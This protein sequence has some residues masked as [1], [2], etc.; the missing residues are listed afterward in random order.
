MFK[1]WET[2]IISLE[3]IYAHSKARASTLALVG[4]VQ[5][6]AK[7]RVVAVQTRVVQTYTKCQSKA[8]DVVTTAKAKGVEI[9]DKAKQAA[10]EMVKLSKKIWRIFKRC[11]AFMA[12]FWKIG[13]QLALKKLPYH[14]HHLKF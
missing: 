11:A 1:L 3:K 2:H 13:Q 10:K 7:A 6:A 14:Y 12:P 9:S 4:S 8:L 5:D